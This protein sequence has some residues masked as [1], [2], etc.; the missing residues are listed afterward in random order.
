MTK[1]FKVP[2]NG[3]LLK[4]N[5][6]KYILDCLKTN[7]ISSSGIYVTKFENKFAK[8]LKKKYAITVSNGTAALQLAIES[9]NLK[10]GSEVILPSFTIISCIL[11]LI[12][13]GLKPILV[14]SDLSTWNMKVDD[15]EKK[16]TKK[17]KAIMAV[18][19]YGMPA[20]MK[21][22]LELAKKYKLKIIEDSAE[23]IGLTYNGKYCGSFGDV[24]TFSFFANK[25]I[26][27]GEGGMIVTD[28]LNIANKC[29]SLRNLFFNNRRRFKHYDLGWNYRL[30]NLQ[31]AIG[32]AQLERIKFFVKKKRKIGEFYQ[33]NLSCLSKY[34]Y[35][36]KIK[37]KFSKNI[38][39]VFGIVLKKGTHISVKKI[40]KQLEK[41][42]IETR[43]F[44]WPLHQQ[45]ILKK[46]GYF[47]NCKCPNSEFLSKNGFYIPSGLS[48]TTKD[49][50]YV[51]KNLVDIIKK[52]YHV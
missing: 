39:W 27:T 19:I 43:N 1:I 29:R 37:N 36:P 11:P 14:D 50:I 38:Y 44:F 16:I 21:K 47:K 46:M 30:T 26:T 34:I 35:L 31:S 22:I 20:N 52:S 9:L 5:E 40:M 13:C 32:L 24:S 7:F 8:F 28:S 15:I 3:P 41:R 33:K 42:G 17:T 6:K 48:L 25:H 4:G 12:R 10:R 49:Q 23:S 45:P 18:H 51:V 2:V